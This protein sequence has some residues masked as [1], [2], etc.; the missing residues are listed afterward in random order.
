MDMKELP[1]FEA[2]IIG[3]TSQGNTIYDYEL[4]LGVLLGQAG[5]EGLDEAVDDLYWQ[6]SFVTA[7]PESF[8]ILD[9]TQCIFPEQENLV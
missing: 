8:I 4:M 5:I 6:L 9:G 2:A 7:T 1:G 3:K